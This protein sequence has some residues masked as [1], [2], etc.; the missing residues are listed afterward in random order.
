VSKLE[1]PMIEAFWRTVGG[2]LVTEFPVVRKSSTCGPRRLDAVILPD[3]ELRHVSWRDVD[4]KA[5]RVIVVQA[6]CERLGMYL[7]GQ[8]VFSAELIKLLEPSSVESVLLCTADD[9]ALRPLLEPYPHLRVVVLP[10]FANP[11]KRR[12]PNV[13]PSLRPG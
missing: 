4:I 2:T 11:G 6:K 8:A 13:N 10:E 5:K 9:S 3:G 12:S 1:T 7:M